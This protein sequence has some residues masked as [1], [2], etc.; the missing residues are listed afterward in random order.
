MSQARPGMQG[1]LAGRSVLVTGGASGIGE[2]TVR[3]LVARGAR[4]AVMDRDAERAH[5]LVAELAAAGTTLAIV[6]DVTREEDCARCVAAVVDAFGPLDVLVNNA[7]GGRLLPTEELDLATWRGM[8]ELNLDGTFLMSQHA[9]RHMLARGRGA[10][11]NVASVHGYVGFARHAAYSA[12]KSGVLN[13]TRS[14]AVEYGTRGIRVNAVCPGVIATPL[15][16]A[17]LTPD[18]EA[19]LAAL[20]PIGRIGLPEEVAAAICF[21]ASDD[22][23]FVTGAS[24][25]VDGGYSAQ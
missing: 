11:V 14:L 22:A 7:G 15:T 20:H 17:Q 10:I 8:I 16:K 23:S 24:L 3:M 13:L 21:L 9:L 12:A 25:M 18:A 2:A 1:S 19:G 5:A 4:V 6:G